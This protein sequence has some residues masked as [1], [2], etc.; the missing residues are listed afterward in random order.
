MYDYNEVIDEFKSS[1][2]DDE[3]YWFNCEIIEINN[4]NYTLYEKNILIY[5]V[6]IKMDR[7]WF[8]QYIRNK[9]INTL[10]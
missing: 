3:L 10:I 6:I 9:K 4:S 8:K 2:N 7:V 5:S 1:L